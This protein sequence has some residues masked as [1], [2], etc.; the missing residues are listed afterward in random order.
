MIY[1]FIV[2]SNLYVKSIQRPQNY[3]F[4][5]ILFRIQYFPGTREVEE[6]VCKVRLS[7][8]PFYLSNC[9]RLADSSGLRRQAERT[10]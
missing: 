1:V 8:L 2:S 7:H 6:A 9:L 3:V 4:T 10:P 5:F